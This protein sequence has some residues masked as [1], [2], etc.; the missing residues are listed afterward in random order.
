MPLSTIFQLY[1]C[2]QFY[3][4]RKP[5]YPEKTTDLPQVT[6]KLYHIMLY[7]VH[8][9][10]SRN[11]THNFSD[12]IK[13]ECG[14]N[15]QQVIGLKKWVPVWYDYSEGR[16]GYRC[17]LSFSV[18]FQVKLWRPYLYGEGAREENMESYDKLRSEDLGNW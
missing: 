3:W 12:C 4:W 16:L 13:G 9:T 17:L 14:W 11:L 5:V 8:L 15:V 10:M 1:H 7:Q 6:D 18:F 2:S